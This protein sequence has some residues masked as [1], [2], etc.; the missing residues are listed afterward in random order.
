MVCYP[1]Q[2]RLLAIFCFFLT[3]MLSVYLAPVTSQIR[4]NTLTLLWICGEVLPQK[5]ML[6]EVEDFFLLKTV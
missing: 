1:N 6:A 3:K 2:V 4:A 5:C